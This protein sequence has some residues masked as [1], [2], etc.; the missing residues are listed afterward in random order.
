[1]SNPVRP[2]VRPVLL[3]FGMSPMKKHHQKTETKYLFIIYFALATMVGAPVSMVFLYPGNDG[4]MSLK[5]AAA[6]IGFWIIILGLVF[7]NI[8]WKMAKSRFDLL[9]EAQ[10]ESPANLLDAKRVFTDFNPENLVN[11]LVIYGHGSVPKL[12]QILRANIW[13]I[14][15]LVFWLYSLALVTPFML[16]GLLPT[17]TPLAII[18]LGC[19]YLL[20]SMAKSVIMGE[21]KPQLIALGLTWNRQEEKA[22]GTWAG[23][24]LEMKFEHTSVTTILKKSAPEFTATFNKNNF[25]TKG[26]ISPS[27]ADLL[28][29]LTDHELWRGVTITSTGLSITVHRKYHLVEETPA[30]DY[31]MCDLWLAKKISGR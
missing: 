16:M 18:A 25:Q 21:Q 28:A 17:M 4:T 13:G 9:A 12:K 8:V 3:Y 5:A 20:F 26:D 7:L 23:H 14:S 31:W 2:R 22:T 30:N 10:T 29:G 24:H 15:K 11:R 19:A 6:A 1:M 27:T